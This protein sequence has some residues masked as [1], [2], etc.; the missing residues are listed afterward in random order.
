VL[1]W[2]SGEDDIILVSAYETDIQIDNPKALPILKQG[3]MLKNNR[4]QEVKKLLAYQ[5]YHISEKDRSKTLENYLKKL[6]YEFTSEEVQNVVNL[7]RKRKVGTRP[8]N[9]RRQKLVK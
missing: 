2:E 3:K 5:W 1:A 4:L 7:A 6:G 9:L 8:K